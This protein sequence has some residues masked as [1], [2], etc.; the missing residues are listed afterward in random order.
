MVPVRRIEHHNLRLPD[1]QLL[2]E[3]RPHRPPDLRVLSTMLLRFLERA[4]LNLPLQRLFQRAVQRPRPFRNLL[5][6]VMQPHQLLG[7]PRLNV[8]RR[9]HKM[10]QC[11]RR[12]IATLR[13]S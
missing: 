11:R 2:S 12:T 8:D 6:N 13:E 3:C 1:H 7:S 4:Y 9:A 10:L 5:P